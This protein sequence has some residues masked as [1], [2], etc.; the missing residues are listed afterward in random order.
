MG[1]HTA[2]KPHR[3]RLTTAATI[4]AVAG[5]ATVG[6]GI[7]NLTVPDTA[8]SYDSSDNA[9]CPFGTV[10]YDTE[11]PD[12]GDSGVVCRAAILAL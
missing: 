6:A 2:P 8:P 5:T 11:N 3:D 12:Q 10:L 9:H 4:L 7:A 1:R